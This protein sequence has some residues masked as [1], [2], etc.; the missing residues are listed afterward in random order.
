MNRRKLKLLLSLVASILILGYWGFRE[1]EYQSSGLSSDQADKEIDGFIIGAVSVEYDKQGNPKQ[2]LV[3]KKMTHYPRSDRTL[4]ETPVV[5][6]HRDTKPPV[7]IKAKE[8]E[9]GPG[10]TEIFL[11]QEVFMVEQTADGF[12]LETSYLRLVPDNDYAE[13]NAAVTLRH[14]S[15]EMRSKGLKAFLAEDRIQ[16]LNNVRGTHESR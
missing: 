12:S 4:L 10:G 11:R 14:R 2:E 1:P 8:G 5:L 16:L 9:I 15:G 13:T 3:S 7:Q 6:V